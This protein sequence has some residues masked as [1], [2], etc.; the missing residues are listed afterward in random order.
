[1]VHDF[2]HKYRRTVQPRQRQVSM[3]YIDEFISIEGSPA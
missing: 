3:K 2:L 1:M